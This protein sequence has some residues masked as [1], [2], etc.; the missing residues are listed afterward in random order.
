M[1]P[2]RTMRVDPLLSIWSTDNLPHVHG[3]AKNVL[4]S[5]DHVGSAIRV[6]I[7]VH[8]GVLVRCASGSSTVVC[9][10]L[11]KFDSVVVASAGDGGETETGVDS[12]LGK[13]VRGCQQVGE[14]GAAAGGELA[15]GVSGASAESDESDSGQKLHVGQEERW[16]KVGCAGVCEDVKW[17]EEEK[18][19]N[20]HV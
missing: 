20:G 13:R 2:Y 8:R 10:R 4:V 5:R 6:E 11:L 17:S 14:V 9:Q 15:L 12:A 18:G 7:L 16:T 19:T 3:G 1:A